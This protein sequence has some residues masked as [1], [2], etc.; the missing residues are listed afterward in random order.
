MQSGPDD[1]RNPSRER[2]DLSI[3]SIFSI[4]SIFSIISI[5]G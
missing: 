4:S 1:L 5:M 2:A 3:F